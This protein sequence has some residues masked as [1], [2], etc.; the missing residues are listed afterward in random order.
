MVLGTMKFTHDFNKVLFYIFMLVITVSYILIF[1]NTLYMK[2]FLWKNRQIKENEKNNV[3]GTIIPM[4]EV[5]DYK[6]YLNSY[7]SG[8]NEFNEDN[9]LKANYNNDIVLT[10]NYNLY[11]NGL[12]FK[13]FFTYILLYIAIAIIISLMKWKLYLPHWTDYIRELFPT[14]AEYVSVMP[15]FL[16]I[17]FP[18]IY[19]YS[20]TNENLHNKYKLKFKDNPEN[21]EN[22]LYGEI[23]ELIDDKFANNRECFFE[24]KKFFENVNKNNIENYVENLELKTAA[25]N[26]FEN[27]KYNIRAQV[28]CKNYIIFCYKL[29]EINK[30][31][32]VDVVKNMRDFLYSCEEAYKENNSTGYKIESISKIKLDFGD[33]N[34]IET[35]FNNIKEKNDTKNVDIIIGTNNEALFKFLDENEDNLDVTKYDELINDVEVS[36]TNKLNS[37]VKIKKT[38]GDPAEY[39]KNDVTIFINLKDS[40]FKYLPL[41]NVDETTEESD[42]FYVKTFIPTSESG[43]M[44]ENPDDVTKE[45]YNLYSDS[46]KKI[47]I[48]NTANFFKDEKIENFKKF[49]NKDVT[50]PTDLST[51]INSTLEDCYILSYKANHD[52][53]NNNPTIIDNVKCIFYK[54]APFAFEKNLSFMGKIFTGKLISDNDL[55]TTENNEYHNNNIFFISMLTKNLFNEEYKDITDEEVTIE[56]GKNGKYY[57]QLQKRVANHYYKKLND[58][59]VLF[60]N[61]IISNGIIF[62]TFTIVVAYIVLNIY[63]K[64]TNINDLIYDINKFLLNT[65]I[66]KGHDYIINLYASLALSLIQGGRSLPSLY[67][68]AAIFIFIILLFALP[69]PSNFVALFMI[70]ILPYLVIIYSISTPV[71]TSV[72]MF[73]IFITTLIYLIEFLNYAKNSNYATISEIISKIGVFTALIVII[74]I[75]I[76]MYLNT[77]IRSIEKNIEKN[78]ENNNKFNMVY[79]SILLLSIVIILP[80][81]YFALSIE[82]SLN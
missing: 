30:Y 54:D 28:I 59:Y 3:A 79:N 63:Y 53:N 66:N 75:L 72:V 50:T 51:M 34:S 46:S 71:I 15:I 36:C 47:L 33:N 4:Q 21:F 29:S 67:L 40:K 55:G 38:N 80:A 32:N 20:F 78:I 42:G 76:Y 13:T 70:Y 60:R 9:C 18:F 37:S 44:L 58:N 22:Y 45:I 65:K 48:F 23:R 1:L 35:I 64:K 12:I 26:I 61:Y 77:D 69:Y 16:L 14:K 31:T 24:L 62:G 5:Y 74:V 7:E 82:F 17:L 68:F 8:Y 10:M 73:I 27:E 49:I 2:L 56:E 6:L 19:L 43:K 25:K 81:T 41:A 52:K 57:V 11:L 39:T